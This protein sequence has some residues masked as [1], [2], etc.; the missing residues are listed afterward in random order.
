MKKT[1]GF[2]KK[3]RRKQ[4]PRLPL[5]RLNFGSNQFGFTAVEQ[6]IKDHYNAP[7]ISTFGHVI[8]DTF[9]V[10]YGGKVL[11][12]KESRFTTRIRYYPTF[13]PVF[14]RR[15]FIISV[16][17]FPFSFHH[18]PIFPFFLFIHSFFH[19]FTL[20]QLNEHT[21]GKI[22]LYWFSRV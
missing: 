5:K 17:S 6:V 2:A 16:Y 20:Y 22:S 15:L 10:Q 1:R 21:G 18:S 19:S 14:I 11:Y 9:Q 13:F 3:M 12:A 7:V 8:K 4:S